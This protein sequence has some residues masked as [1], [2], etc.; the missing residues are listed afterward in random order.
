MKATEKQ[1]NFIKILLEDYTDWRPSNIER[2]R[3]FQLQPFGL[4]RKINKS[5]LNQ[6]VSMASDWQKNGC[7]IDFENLTIDDASLV[8]TLLKDYSLI[9]V[10]A[11]LNEQLIKS[12][13]GL[14][15]PLGKVYYG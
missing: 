11:F 2:L 9:K 7:L 13:L 10:Y 5:E 8:I 3:F 6:I 12:E 15:T 1:I 4:N 14:E